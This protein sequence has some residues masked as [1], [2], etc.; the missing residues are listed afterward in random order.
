M[1]EKKI[2]SMETTFY[3]A[4]WCILGSIIVISAL[5]Y[6]TNF[7]LGR[8]LLPCVFHKV[9]GLYCPGCGGTRAV[10]FLL[11]GRL[12]ASFIYHPFVIYCT[13][14]GGWF[15]ISQTIERL[16]KHRLAIGMKYHDYY[17]WIVLAIVAINFVVKNLLLLVWHIDLLAL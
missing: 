7:N 12:W 14:L 5:L 6:I 3:I 11:H 9:T 16:T 8:Y 13:V 2:V 1:N 15:M 10:T 4:G 17:L